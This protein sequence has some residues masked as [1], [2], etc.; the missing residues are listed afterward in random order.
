MKAKRKPS[1]GLQVDPIHIIGEFVDDAN[2]QSQHEVATK[3]KPKKGP[4]KK[5]KPGKRPKE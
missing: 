3:V 2:E 1:G 5:P 4:A